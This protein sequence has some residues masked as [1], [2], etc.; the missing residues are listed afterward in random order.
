MTETPHQKF[1]RV[2]P[3]RVDRLLHEI[4]L[5]GNLGNRNHYEYGQD[6]MDKI[7]TAVEEELKIAKSRFSVKRTEK[8]KL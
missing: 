2:A 5:I 1:K 3:K 7:F 4:R 6:E 8:F